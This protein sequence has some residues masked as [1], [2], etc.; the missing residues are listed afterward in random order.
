M[1]RN[2]IAYRELKETRRSNRAREEETNRANIAKET[3]ENRSNTAQEAETNRHN[4]A[5][6]RE[7][8]RHNRSDEGI[9]HD[10]NK[11]ALY[12]HTVKAISKYRPA[13]QISSPNQYQYFY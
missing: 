7:T 13:S 11:V 8:A 9:R 3:E 4:V 1:T 10:A 6:E 2:Q 5:A 12:G